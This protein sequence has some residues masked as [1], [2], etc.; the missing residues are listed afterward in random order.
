MELGESS[1]RRKL[2]LINAIDSLFLEAI[3]SLPLWLKLR[4]ESVVAISVSK[5]GGI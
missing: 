4:K 3:L 5:I 1:S 2:C